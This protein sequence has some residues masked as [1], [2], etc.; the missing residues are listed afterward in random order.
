MFEFS[1]SLSGGF[2]IIHV[3]IEKILSME[4]TEKIL[5]AWISTD[6]YELWISCF[7]SWKEKKKGS[8]IYGLERV[9]K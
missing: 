2:F 3:Y 6:T 5:V 9:K 7:L 4:E 8:S 1:D